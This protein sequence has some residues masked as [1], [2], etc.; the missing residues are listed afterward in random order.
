MEEGMTCPT[1]DE[2]WSWA[3]LGGG[4]WLAFILCSNMWFSKAR[5]SFYYGV[6][7]SQVTGASDKPHDCDWLKS[8]I[9][10]K[11]CSYSRE[12]STVQ[13]RP[14]RF[15]YQDVSYDEGK[16]WTIHAMSTNGTD[17]LYSTDDGKTWLVD[18]YYSGPVKP[19]VT[20]VWLKKEEQ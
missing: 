8:P 1:K 2:V 6:D 4:A 12:V 14:N 13:V 7:Y 9:G 10:S 11:E 19:S 5:L 15:G 20:V 16:T 18:S 17:H 3:V